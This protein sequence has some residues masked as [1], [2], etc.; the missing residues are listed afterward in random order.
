M[1]LRNVLFGGDS[2][3]KLF[4]RA[5]FE[6]P[7]RIKTN[8]E[9][10][11]GKENP[12]IK[13]ETESEILLKQ[14]F[15]PDKII[16]TIETKTIKGNTEHEQMKPHLEQMIRLADISEKV[17][18][19]RDVNGKIKSVLN[20]QTLYADWEKWKET[21]I[22]TAFSSEKDRQKF[23]QTYEKGLENMVEGLKKSFQHIVLLPEIYH[24]KNYI[25]TQYPDKT[26][27]TKLTS[28]LVP[29]MVIEYYMKATKIESFQDSGVSIK[30]EVT[31][32]TEMVNDHIAPM[33]NRHQEYTLKDYLFEITT[34]Y[35]F[36]KSTAKIKRANFLLREKIHSNL[37]YTLAIEIE[38][39]VAEKTTI[40][41]KESQRKP[42]NQESRKSF[43]ADEQ[44]NKK[45]PKNKG[46]FLDEKETDIK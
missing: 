20:T 16:N 2:A 37:Q 5:D 11:M 18:V 46:F 26:S 44:E 8:N 14:E 9:F 15:Q 12:I 17:V 19:E 29:D 6:S 43:L 31:N 38:E 21:K 22:Q 13:L 1:S 45:N 10:I 28:K 30:S 42:E 32:E 24:F 7:Y 34:N 35:S 40:P 41:T 25:S 23:I 33:Y 36:E 39:I 3:P 27:K 4:Q